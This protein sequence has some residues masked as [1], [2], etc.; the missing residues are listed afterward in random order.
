MVIGGK[1]F[2]QLVIG[3]LI[4]ITITQTLY[5]SFCQHLKWLLRSPLYGDIQNLTLSKGLAWNGLRIDNRTSSQQIEQWVG[6]SLIYS[7]ISNCIPNNYTII[8]RK[9]IKEYN[10]GNKI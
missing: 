2:F 4:Q 5:G 3:K 8:E 10:D 7:L 1:A 9:L 6:I